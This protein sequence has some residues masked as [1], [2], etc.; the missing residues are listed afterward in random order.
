[1]SD[2]PTRM[3]GSRYEFAHQIGAGGFC[4]VWRAQDVV[5]DRP[6]AV[7]LLRPG[8]A[9][10]LDTITRF[11]NEAQ[12]AG[13]LAHVNVA[14]VYDFHEEEPGTPPYLVMELIE[15]PSLAQVI[16]NGP[17]SPADTMDIIA[18]AAAGLQAAHQAGLV[19]RDIKPAN[20]LL[21]AGRTVKITDFGISHSVSAAPITGTGMLIGTPHYFPPERTEGERATP[22]GDLYSLGIVG[23]ECLAGA[24]PFAGTPLEVALAHRDRPLPQ[25]PAAV[26]DEVASFIGW[27]TARDP[28][29]RPASADLVARHAAD[30]R[31]RLSGRPGPDGRP[32]VGLRDRTT[33]FAG[34]AAAGATA[35]FGRPNPATTALPR[36]QWDGAPRP[37]RRW[38]AVLAAAAVVALAAGAV[39]VIAAMSNQGRTT[40]PASSLHSKPATPTAQL[41]DVRRAAMVGEAAWWAK[42]QLRSEGFGVQILWRPSDLEPFGH[43]ITV[44][45][46]GPQPPGTLITIVASSGLHFRHGDGNNGGGDGGG[47]GGGG[48]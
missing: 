32:S 34:V 25:L 9:Q 43:V 45:P 19:H 6:V 15:G 30:L 28:A 22:A 11:K 17:L 40:P 26:P 47:G 5:L 20:I 13:R 27:L 38:T 33:A 35:P 37:R 41:I 1:M 29:A 44:R 14:R 2:I 7:K 42:A 8:F 16:A 18:Q 23:F 12:L 21:E 4:D 48:N 3:L 46:A 31:D 10:D 24:V 39:A 36:D